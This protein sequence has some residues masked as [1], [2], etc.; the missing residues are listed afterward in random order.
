[1]DWGRPDVELEKESRHP[2]GLSC[3]APAEVC[4][5]VRD[6]VSEAAR[7]VRSAAG[8]HLSKRLLHFL[9][10]ILSPVLFSSHLY[11]ANS[12]MLEIDGSDC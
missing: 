3:R 6:I 10:E 11:R 12:R 4:A 7:W 1:M 2:G 8:V 9:T 5:K